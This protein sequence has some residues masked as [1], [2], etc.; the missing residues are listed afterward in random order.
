[1]DCRA[2][3]QSEAFISKNIIGYIENTTDQDQKKARFCA[4]S[5]LFFALCEIFD[6]KNADIRFSEDGK[7]YLINC[8]KKI[9]ISVS[10]CIGLSAVCMS[11]DGEVGIDIQDEIDLERADRLK[12]RFFKDL[13]IKNN[14]QNE[15]KILIFEFSDGIPALTT[16][17]EKDLAIIDST[18]D[19]TEKWSLAES[20][21]KCD[22]GGFGMAGDVSKIQKSCYSSTVRL[23]RENKAFALSISIK[24]PIM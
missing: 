7:P 18:L 20:L 22:G 10:H 6:E 1:M 21:L 4:Y 14:L 2:L 11:D 15:N 5:S 17:G 24:K 9:Y 3:R 13:E 23:M 16:F 12:N 8:D 19:F